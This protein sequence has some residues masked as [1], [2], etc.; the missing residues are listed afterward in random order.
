MY[1][2]ILFY[3]PPCIFKTDTLIQDHHGNKHDMCYGTEM[4]ARVII[5]G[6]GVFKGSRQWMNSSPHECECM[7]GHIKATIH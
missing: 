6:R 4:T 1:E 2:D 7:H 3:H 5:G